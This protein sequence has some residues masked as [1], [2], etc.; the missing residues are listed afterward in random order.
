MLSKFKKNTTV[1]SATE[2]LVARRERSL[3]AIARHE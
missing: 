3:Q 2:K 1:L